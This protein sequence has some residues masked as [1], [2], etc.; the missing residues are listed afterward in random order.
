MEGKQL[1][2]MAVIQVVT[3]F[4]LN[5]LAGTVPASRRVLLGGGYLPAPGD[6]FKR[7]GT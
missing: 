7:F 5:L 6:D 3:M 4:A 2:Q 1:L